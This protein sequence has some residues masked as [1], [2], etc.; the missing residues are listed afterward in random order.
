MGAKFLSFSV[1]PIIHFLLMKKQKHFFNVSTVYVLKEKKTLETIS[2]NLT[3]RDNL[4][5]ILVC[6]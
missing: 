4:V 5:Y 1:L 6:R 3:S 2:N